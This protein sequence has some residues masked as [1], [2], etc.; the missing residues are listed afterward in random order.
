SGKGMTVSLYRCPA[1]SL[2]FLKRQ[3]PEKFD[4]AILGFG[5]LSYVKYADVLV[6]HIPDSDKWGG[7][8]DL[9]K[10][11]G[12]LL[13]SVYNENSNAYRVVQSRQYSEDSLSIAA[14]MDLSGG[15]LR[16][17]NRHFAC[18]AFSLQQTVRLMQRAGLC[19]DTE[20][21]VGTFP[22]LH[23]VCD[24]TVAHSKWKKDPV[25]PLGVFNPNLYEA[26]IAHSRIESDHGHYIIGVGWRTV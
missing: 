25:F 16:V 2:S 11:N 26:D 24:N 20:N 21:D 18:E 17:G 6:P 8:V 3:F 23:L 22:Q 9:L 12:G 4:F 10:D 1:E 14:M 19:V 7:V 13:F 5:L 15:F